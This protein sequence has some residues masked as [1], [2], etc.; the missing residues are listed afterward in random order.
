MS[1]TAMPEFR[2]TYRIQLT[3][4][5][6][7]AETREVVVPYVQE[8]GVSHLYLSPSLQAQKGST[9]GYDVVDPTTIS[10]DL[11]GEAEFRKLADAARDAGLGILL[12]IVP[13]HMAT[14]EQENPFWRDLDTREK[15]FDWDRKTG[16]YRRFFDV[17]ELAGVRVEKILEPGYPL[18]PWPVEGTTG[19]EF[20]NDSTALF[21]D[22][23]G[24]EPMT[25][26]Y[27]ELTGETRDFADIA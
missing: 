20:A 22:P 7:F 5:F 19:Y 1:A 16:W 15:F 27:R 26:L 24:E 17:G 8:L 14:N 11:G 3:D 6:G 12:D 18:R 9:H 21:V 2:C 13:N 10:A 25:E 23:D 4:T